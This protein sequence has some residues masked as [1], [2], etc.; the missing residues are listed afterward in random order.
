[1]RTKLAFAILI[2][3]MGIITPAIAADWQ[4]AA[5]DAKGVRKVFGPYSTQNDCLS[6]RSVEVL[7]DGKWIIVSECEEH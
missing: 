7:I 4:F 5:V 3:T 1:M 2:A 6:A